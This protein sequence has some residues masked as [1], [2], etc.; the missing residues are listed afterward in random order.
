MNKKGF[1][2]IEM[3]IV[4]FIISIIATISMQHSLSTSNDKEN[5]L[6]NDLNSSINTLQNF[7][8]EYSD[9]PDLPKQ[10]TGWGNSKL[11]YQGVITDYS[12]KPLNNNIISIENKNCNKDFSGIEI[13]VYNE[14]IDKT[15]KYLDCSYEL[16]YI[17][18]TD[19]NTIDTTDIQNTLILQFDEIKNKM[20]MVVN[21][22]NVDLEL[23][24]SK[25]KFP[26]G[27]TESNNGGVNLNVPLY[28]YGKMDVLD[29]ELTYIDSGISYELFPDLTVKI[30]S[31]IKCHPE[32]EYITSTR[33]ITDK[34]ADY[35]KYGDINTDFKLRYK[36]EPLYNGYRIYIYS[37]LVNMRLEYDYC[38]DLKPRIL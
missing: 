38:L 23:I 21:A 3:V 28:Y 30:E 15:V 26:Y 27:G 1:T 2:L 19:T 9:V 36:E 25:Y 16:P 31:K 20:N 8:T 33:Y 18:E 14:D 17:E 10:I 11:K 24:D 32:Q 13:S 35:Y 34:T 22:D 5:D 29:K 12:I 37:N 6:D 4:M 7:Y